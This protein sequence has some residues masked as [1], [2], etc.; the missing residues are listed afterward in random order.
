MITQAVGVL[1]ILFFNVW[2]CEWLV[3]NTRLRPLSTALLVILLTAVLANIGLIPSASANFP[4]YEGIFTYLAPIS[5]FYLLL[6]VNLSNLRSAGLPML[7]MFGIGA[8]GTFVGVWV[9]MKLIDGP[10][11]IGPLYKA[12]GGMFTGTYTGG[13]V[14]FNAVALHY[15]VQK[16]GTLYA[17]AVAVDNLITALWMVVTIGS[18]ALLFRW[19]PRKEALQKGDTKTG[20]EPLVGNTVFNVSEL[21]MLALLGLFSLWISEALSTWLA[22]SG[23]EIPSILILTTI[24][25]LLAQIPMVHHLKGARLLG[26][27]S[28]YIFLAVIGAYCELAAMAE[29]GGLAISLLLFAFVLVLVHGVFCYG[30]GGLLK[31]DWRLI[32]IASQANIGGSSTALALAGSLGRSDL[33]LPAILIGSLGNGIGTYLGFLMAGI[34]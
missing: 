25:L 23:F 5:I 27:I 10:A 16:A 17:G 2:I 22:N 14:N 13:S 31:Y 7:L 28:V 21:A 15:E 33:I 1:A 19:F 30:I 32:S 9:G 4:L 26:M 6:E 20:A 24:A 29:I 8:L 18:P 3:N 11:T 12:L 34:L